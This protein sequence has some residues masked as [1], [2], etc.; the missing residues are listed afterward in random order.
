M[1]YLLFRTSDVIKK[2]RQ[3]YEEECRKAVAEGREIPVYVPLARARLPWIF[4]FIVSV[5]L[6]LVADM[7]FR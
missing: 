4:A 1:N 2:R 6:L 7:A 5:V 3:R